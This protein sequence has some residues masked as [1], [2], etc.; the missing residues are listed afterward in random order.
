[1]NLLE[2]DARLATRGG[3]VT[4]E[5]DDLLKGQDAAISSGS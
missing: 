2:P 1:M 4:E 3:M 5:A